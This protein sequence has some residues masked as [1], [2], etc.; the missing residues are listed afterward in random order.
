[1]ETF[2]VNWV[3]LIGKYILNVYKDGIMDSQIFNSIEEMGIYLK[4]KY[5][6]T[7]RC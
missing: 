3:E 5:E 7:I 2:K 4:E 6:Y 1:M